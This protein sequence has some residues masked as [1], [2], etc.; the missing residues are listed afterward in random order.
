MKNGKIEWAKVI[1]GDQ[2][3]DIES[4]ASTSD[5]GCIVG[6]YFKSRVINVG[7]GVNEEE[8]IIASKGGSYDDK[9]L[10]IKYNKERQSR[11]GKRN[12]RSIC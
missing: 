4:V 6:G 10:V 12:R 1:G 9:G 11:M 7:E 5:G 8:V 3:D 2:D